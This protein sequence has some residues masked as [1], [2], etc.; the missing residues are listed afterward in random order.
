MSS[1][2]SKR[3]KSKTFPLH[4]LQKSSGSF[5]RR[6]RRGAALGADSTN[7]IDP[8]SQSS[9]LETWHTFQGLRYEPGTGLLDARTRWLNPPLARFHQRDPNEQA[10]V[11]ATR[12]S[13]NGEAPAFAAAFTP[14]R[15]YPDGP[16]AYQFALGNPV[17]GLDP[18]GLAA[19]EAAHILP[20][21]L[22]GAQDGPLVDMAPADHHAHDDTFKR[23]GFSRREHADVFWG[24]RKATKGEFATQLVSANDRRRIMGE[25]LGAAGYDTTDPKTQK[26]IDEA[27]DMGTGKGDL[28]KGRRGGGGIRDLPRIRPRGVGMG[29]DP[30]TGRYSRRRFIQD[31]GGGGGSGFRR[32]LRNGAA[33]VII[34]GAL[35]V[36]GV[37]QS[38]AHAHYAELIMLTDKIRARN[39]NASFYDEIEALSIITDLNQ[40]LG[41]NNFTIYGGWNYWREGFDL[42]TGSD[43]NGWW[44]R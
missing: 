35:I 44:A 25:A 40:E 20:V 38:Q 7:P 33:P 29:I 36:A 10:L 26:A 1:W 14:W 16:N 32:G 11:L 30:Q 19:S 4:L 42:T 39:G 13:K 6:Q 17:T 34:T 37:Y 5:C 31:A 3:Q 2:P 18:A 24:K 9:L 23:Y 41:G 12:L 22:G 27:L 15:Q 21:F 43:R 8:A 28:S